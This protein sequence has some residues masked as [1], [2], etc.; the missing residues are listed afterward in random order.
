MP[1]MFSKKWGL[2]PKA[3]PSEIEIHEPTDLATIAFA[4]G[5]LNGWLRR[6]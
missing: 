5:G 3:Q 6:R 1:W 4:I 2:R